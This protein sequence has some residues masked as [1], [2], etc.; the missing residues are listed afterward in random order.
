MWRSYSLKTLPGSKVATLENR[1]F[2]HYLKLRA[3]HL[4]LY[5]VDF[6]T[7]FTTHSSSST[8]VFGSRKR[9]S[10]IFAGNV[11]ARYSQ[12]N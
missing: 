12:Y 5:R 2:A 4:F 9:Y 8:N 7:A 11:L 6:G 10:A 1:A 3:A